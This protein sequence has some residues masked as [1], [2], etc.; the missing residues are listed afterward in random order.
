MLLLLI[1]KRQD[2]LQTGTGSETGTVK[3]SYGSATLVSCLSA[4]PTVA[5]CIQER[6]EQARHE[7]CAAEAEA[8]GGGTGQ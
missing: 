6:D 3:N 2:F 5:C 7:A 1:L 8:Q 4:D